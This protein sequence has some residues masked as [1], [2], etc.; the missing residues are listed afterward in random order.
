MALVWSIAHIFWETD[1][2]SK[3][4]IQKWPEEHFATGDA[5]IVQ[6]MRGSWDKMIIA[7]FALIEMNSGLEQ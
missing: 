5:F 7:S 3:P 1:L 2:R 6:P 4:S